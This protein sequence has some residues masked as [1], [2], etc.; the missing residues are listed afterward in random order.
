MPRVAWD[1][2]MSVGVEAFDND[3]RIMIGLIN[4]LDSMAEAGAGPKALAPVFA[5]LT[6][7]VEGHFRREEALMAELG[8]DGF[9]THRANHDRLRAGVDTLHQQFADESNPDLVNDLVAFLGT[10]WQSH[11]LVDDMAYRP[12]FERKLSAAPAA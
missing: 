9:E 8:Y 1:E 11:I 5:V 10:W 2:T 3:H 7:Y 12:Y 4:Q 6:D